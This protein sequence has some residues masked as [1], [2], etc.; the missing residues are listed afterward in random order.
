MSILQKIATPQL[1][2]P[3]L[4]KFILDFKNYN[5]ELRKIVLDRI[6]D[7]TYPYKQ[8][9]IPEHFEIIN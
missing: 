1:G 2:R 5:D 8:W 6:Y 4:D 9:V 3:P 7:P